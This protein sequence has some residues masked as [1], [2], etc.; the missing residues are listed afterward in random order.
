MDNYYFNQWCKKAVSG[1]IFPPDQVTVAEELFDH[2]MDHYEDLVAQGYDEI[3]ARDRTIEA[4]G[5]PYEIAPQLAA[6]HRPF[7]GYFLRATRILLILL[8]LITVIPFISFLYKAEY[9]EPETYRYDPYTDTYISDEIG[10][11]TRVM[12]DEPK[13]QFKSDGYTLELTQAVWSHTAFADAGEADSDMFCFRI[14]ITNPLPWADEP[15]ILQWIYAQDSE[16]NIYAPWCSGITGRYLTTGGIYHTNPFTWT[17]DLYVSGFCSQN[18]DW[19]D[20]CYNRDG[21]EFKLRIDLP[22]GDA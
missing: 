4:M 17:L 9:S 11:T 22:G 15:D 18:A 3:T 10:V 6:L 13:Q 20:I 8:L 14:E 2:M 5:D 19:L 12:Y 7:W 1:I 16:G 21:R